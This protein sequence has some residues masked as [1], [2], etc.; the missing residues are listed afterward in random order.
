MARKN[1][2]EDIERELLG[3]MPRAFV[4]MYYGLVEKAFAQYT[5]PLGHAGEGGGGGKKRFTTHNGGLADE[6]AAGEKRRIDRTL[7]QMV[8]DIDEGTRK[9]RPKCQ[10]CGRF[11]DGAWDYCAWCGTHKFGDEVKVEEQELKAAG[12]GFVRKVP[13]AVSEPPVRAPKLR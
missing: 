11:V 8:R 13:V 12:G 6:A 9:E 3:Y 5:S 1:N 10:H 2:V 7:R 4:L